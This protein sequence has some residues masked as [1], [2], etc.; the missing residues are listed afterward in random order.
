MS[1]VLNLRPPKRPRE[2]FSWPHF[3]LPRR[4]RRRGREQ[5]TSERGRP[6]VHEKG[7]RGGQMLTTREPRDELALFDASFCCELTIICPPT[8]CILVRLDRPWLAP[9]RLKAVQCIYTCVNTSLSSLLFLPVCKLTSVT[10]NLPTTN[11]QTTKRNQPK[12]RRP[13]KPEERKKDR[14]DRIL[15]GTGHTTRWNPPTHLPPKRQRAS[16]ECV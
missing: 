13:Q 8:Q 7:L 9:V 11:A 10:S 14:K 12:L 6:Q 5:R 3:R 1:T 16:R 4:V 2:A 15:A